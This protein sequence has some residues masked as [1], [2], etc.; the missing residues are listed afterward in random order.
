MWREQTH[1]H[2]G[3][4]IWGKSPENAASQLCLMPGSSW[5]NAQKGEGFLLVTSF[6]HKRGVA[7]GSRCN[8]L[9]MLRGTIRELWFGSV[10][11]VCRE[12]PPRRRCSRA[13]TGNLPTNTDD[14]EGLLSFLL[15]FSPPI[16]R[17]TSLH[18]RLL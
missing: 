7:P 12:L 18:E 17:A 15:F 3:S 9:A 1:W 6:C 5:F 8:S 14:L 4:K 11:R 2:H 16:N 13:S 10:L